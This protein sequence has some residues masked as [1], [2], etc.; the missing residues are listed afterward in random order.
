MYCNGCFSNAFYVIWLKKQ[1]IYNS[2]GYL[3]MCLN[4]QEMVWK[5][6]PIPYFGEGRQETGWVV[7]RGLQAYLWHFHFLQGEVT[8]ALLVY[9]NFFSKSQNKRLKSKSRERTIYSRD[10]GSGMTLVSGT[11]SRPVFMVRTTQTCVRTPMWTLR[12]FMQTLQER[13]LLFF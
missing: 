4:A 7:I 6:A 3:E 10:S 9:W 8:Q 2:C 1:T 11:G 5:Q 13:F 12:L